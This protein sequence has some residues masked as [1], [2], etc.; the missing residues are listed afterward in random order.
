[1]SESKFNQLCVLRTRTIPTDNFSYQFV[2]VACEW[3]I[4]ICTYVYIGMNNIHTYTILSAT[5]INGVL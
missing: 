5:L 1:M 4:Y 2:I 3:K